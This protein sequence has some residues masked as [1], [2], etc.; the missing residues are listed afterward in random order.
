MRNSIEFKFRLIIPI[1]LQFIRLMITP[2]RKKTH[3][4]ELYPLN[5]FAIHIEELCNK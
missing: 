4:N 3:F 5:F 2:S 1:L